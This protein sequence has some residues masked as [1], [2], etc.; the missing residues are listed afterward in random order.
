VVQDRCD[1][2]LLITH[3]FPKMVSSDSGQHIQ[4]KDAQKSLKSFSIPAT[5]ALKEGL[6]F[7]FLAT[8][9]KGP[10][11]FA[12]LSLPMFQLHRIVQSVMQ[13]QNASRTSANNM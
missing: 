2:I 8:L 1:S 12:D 5:R 6:H 4:K 11:S 9:V 10:N 3:A 7:S 13:Y